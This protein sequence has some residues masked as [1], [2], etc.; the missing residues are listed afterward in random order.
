MIKPDAGET[1]GRQQ[2]TKQL[3]FKSTAVPPKQIDKELLYNYLAG[4]ISVR[5]GA[6]E[7]AYEH[8]MA[9]A[10]EAKDP[11]AASK[12]ARLAWRQ[13]DMGKAASAIERWIEYD[14]NSLPARQLALLQALR[15]N[16]S[17]AAMTQ[18]RAII[19]IAEALGKDGFLLLGSALA[20]AKGHTKIDL[21]KSLVREYPDN[22]HAHY[23]LALVASQEK[24]FDQALEA[25]DAASH[26]APDWDTPYLLRVQIHAMH[27]DGASAERVL[28][29]AAQKHPDAVTIQE[30]Y[31]RLLMQQKK[32]AEALMHF[33]QA[34]KQ[35]PQDPEL[36]YLVG[37]LALQVEDWDLARN[38]WQKLRD[39]PRFQ[40][41]NEAWYFLG[42]L[43]ELQGN[44]TQAVKNYRQVKGGRLKHDA[45][46]RIAILTGKLGKLQESKEM[47]R[48]L[49][50]TAPQQ[51]VQ[52]YITEAEMLKDL[53]KTDQALNIYTEAIQAY[54][55]NTD[56]LYARGLMAA[57]MGNI[58]L[59]EADFKAV[60]KLKPDDT[61]TLNALGYTLADLTHRYQEAYKY[62]SAAYK[63]NPESPAI[64]D[65][66][67][68]VLYRLGRTEES[69]K[70]LHQA[71]EK[72]D[73]PEIAAHLGEVLW[74]TGAREEA[75]KTWKQAIER[76]PDS[77]KLR[78]TA[79]RF[80]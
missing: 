37:I 70:F 79:Q 13:G 5:R 22:A 44:L 72:L 31:G 25:V 10:Q 77:K 59:A 46:L 2:A 29:E 42:Q 33:Q 32:Y 71:A 49:R 74:A 18:A 24:Q 8:L 68:W 50:I 19:K 65:S 26:L 6:W 43:E 51:A 36:L 75:R 40:K 62:V 48:N 17:A 11:V 14:P 56:L 67:G 47:F 57:D 60:L 64:L 54:P 28:R 9:A 58:D 61:D 35:K 7:S 4:E 73:D 80:Q 3:P 39:E 76:H 78:Q 21:M 41:Q 1:A 63:Q 55:E 34:L 16:E 53:G 23:A 69:L 45:L 12:A 66:M 52:A 20:S 15:K 30:A 27:G 38:T